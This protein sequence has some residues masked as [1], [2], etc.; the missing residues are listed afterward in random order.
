MAE[1]WE[2]TS[3]TTWLRI[4]N[5]A[6][7]ERDALAFCRRHHVGGIV[8]FAGTV[9]DHNE[10]LTGVVA[11]HY[12]VALDLAAARLGNIAAEAFDALPELAALVVH[13]RVGRVALG[14]TAVVV[15]AAA[16]H[17]DTAF[18][19]A[20]Y[21]IDAVKVAVPLIKQELTP[22]SS[23]WAPSSTPLDDIPRVKDHPQP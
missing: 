1:S 20:R 5:D 11:L 9:R 19:A 15:A 8:V 21:A 18:Q 6:L 12:E 7:D 10:D 17:R 13:H 14:E 16:P 23:R 22:S 4:G 2:S 3:T